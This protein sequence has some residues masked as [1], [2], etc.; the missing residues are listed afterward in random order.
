[1]RAARHANFQVDLIVVR[2]V[3]ARIDQLR[4]L[5]LAQRY[6]SAICSAQIN[7]R[8]VQATCADSF[9]LLAQTHHCALAVEQISQLSVVVLVL[10]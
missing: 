6:F 3:Q 10:I 4:R 8:H 7:R 2:K 5:H 1:M 9:Q